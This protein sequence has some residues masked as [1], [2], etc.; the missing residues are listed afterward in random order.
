MANC[1]DSYEREEKDLKLRLAHVLERM[2]WEDTLPDAEKSKRRLVRYIQSLPRAAEEAAKLNMPWIMF[3]CIER[4]VHHCEIALGPDWRERVS[5]DRDA[6]F[7]GD[8][9]EGPD[10]EN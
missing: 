4:I 10:D 3:G 5:K 1:E 8:D 9:E 6:W 2:E 7:E